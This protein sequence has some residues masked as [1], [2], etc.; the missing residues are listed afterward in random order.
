MNHKHKFQ[1]EHYPIG[2][3]FNNDRVT[4]HNETASW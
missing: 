3:M 4:G 2:T 1:V